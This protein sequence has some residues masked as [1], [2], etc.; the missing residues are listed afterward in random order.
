MLALP[1][2]HDTLRFLNKMLIL[3]L[4]EQLYRGTVCR[5][6]GVL[7]GCLP[8]GAPQARPLTPLLYITYLA[9]GE[10]R[11]KQHSSF[12]N[13]RTRSNSRYTNPT[14]RRLPIR[15]SGIGQI[16]WQA[17]PR[18]MATAP[19]RMIFYLLDRLVQLCQILGGKVLNKDKIDYFIRN[20][21]RG[22]QKIEKIT[23]EYIKYCKN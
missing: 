9:A 1:E 12:Q 15:P 10:G 16:I 18:A 7:K 21:G 19:F 2:W 11:G 14:S 20:G 5:G 4:V 22:V 23:E 3:E 17:V 6:D 13:N 8:A